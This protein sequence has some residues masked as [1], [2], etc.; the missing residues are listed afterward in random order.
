MLCLEMGVLALQALSGVLELIQSGV[1]LSFVVT[2]II[3]SVPQASGFSSKWLLVGSPKWG[4]ECGR[5]FS[6]VLLHTQLSGV[7]CGCGSEGSPYSVD[8]STPPSTS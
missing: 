5:S 3:F 1:G 6:V 4:L 8:P 2:M 7:S